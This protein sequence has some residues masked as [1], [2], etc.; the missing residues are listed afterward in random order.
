MASNFAIEEKT[1]PR[2]HPLRFFKLID[3]HLIELV[4][5]HGDDMVRF[6][7]HTAPDAHI[8][9][10]NNYNKEDI[11][12]IKGLEL[13]R[14]IYGA[15][16]GITKSIEYL[17][18][19][20]R[21]LKPFIVSISEGVSPYR[22]VD[23]KSISELTQVLKKA[24]DH[25][26]IVIIAAGN[27]KLNYARDSYKLGMNLGVGCPWVIPA[28]GVDHNLMALKSARY[29]PTNKYKVLYMT[30]RSS[31]VATAKVSGLIALILE[32]DPG[33]TPAEVKKVVFE[34]ADHH[35]EEHN[36]HVYVLNIA[37]ALKR[38]D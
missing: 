31:S 22:D 38:I 19:T 17:L 32:K 21:P 29:D 27:I 8:M 37:R 26:I 11:V 34:T 14:R 5:H 24:H 35:E 25:G 6:I 2:V 36:R 18:D 20:A 1:V 7:N 30:A 23:K 4:F 12:R 3:S 33:L 9:C 16:L 28:A 15:P 10:I 13:R